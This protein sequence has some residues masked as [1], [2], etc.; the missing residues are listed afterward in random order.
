MAKKFA[1]IERFLGY[2]NKAD[3]TNVDPHYLIYGSQNVLVNDQDKLQIRRGYTVDGEESSALTPIRHSYDWITSAGSERNLRGY[4]TKLEY[5]YVDS[6]GNVSWRDIKKAFGATAAINFATWWSATEQKDLLLFVDG[7]EPDIYVWSGAVTTI[8]SVTANTITKQGTTTWGEERFLLS[9]NK[10]L[11]ID[12]IEYTYTGGEGTT[13]LTGVTPDPTL[14]SHAVGSVAHQSVYVVSDKPTSTIANSIIEVLK[15]Q[16]YVADTTLRTAY[17]SKNTDFTDFT[18]TS[19]RAPGDPALLTLDGTATAFVPQEEDMYIAAGQDMWF[20]TRFTL[21][22]DLTAEELKVERLKTAPKGGAWA[23]ESLGNVKNSVMFL[24]RQRTIDTLGRVESINTPDSVELSDV[25]KNEI[26]SYDLTIPPHF[27]FLDSNMFIVFPSESKMLI[28]NFEKG[29]WQPPQVLPGRRLAIIDG[30]LYMHSNAVAETYKL[31][32]GLSDDGNAILARALFAYRSYGKPWWRKVHD[33]WYIEG[34]VT[35]NTTIDVRYLYDYGGFTQVVSKEIDGS[36]PS[37]IYSTQADGSLGKNPLGSQPFGSILDA[38]T[39]LKKF[40]IVHTMNAQAYYEI[41]VE[42]STNSIDATW[43]L[44]RQG[45]NV[46]ES[47]K[48]NKQIKP[49]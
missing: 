4:S 38:A 22:A 36:D 39:D 31:F 20:K 40:R 41:A 5:R 7:I 46:R 32:D 14:G 42:L 44:L 35:S 17:V 30:E 27:K 24:T 13:T 10:K 2:S 47:D 49:R 3:V 37:I 45:G 16:A 33:E 12:N 34:Y 19:P 8:A 11:W 29:F 1:L 18:V 43:E 28:Y 9:S 48:D 6:D 25:I 26:L 15:N 23:Q 21:S